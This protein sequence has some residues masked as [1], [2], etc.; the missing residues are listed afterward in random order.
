MKQVSW[1]R[2]L[3]LVS[4]PPK[5]SVSSPHPVSNLRLLRYEAKEGE[6]V[7]EQ[8]LRRMQ[9][10][11]QEWNQSYWED[12]NCLFNEQKAA[13][14]EQESRSRDR[15]SLSHDELSVFYKR[16]LDENRA[17]HMRYSM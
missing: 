4:P 3:P 5:V 14:M 13:F 10:E 15:T 8:Q 1:R 11:L 7:A 16:F 17:K 2:F 6:S 12:H 9:S